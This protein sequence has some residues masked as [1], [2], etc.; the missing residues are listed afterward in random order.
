MAATQN[1]KLAG[2]QAYLEVKEVHTGEGAAQ[3]HL[4]VRRKASAA[5]K[6]G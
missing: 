3:V 2:K 4:Y 6:G 5:S 1:E